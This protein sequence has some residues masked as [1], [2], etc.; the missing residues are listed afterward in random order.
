META[1]CLMAVH[2]DVDMML[3]FVRSE[4]WA[5]LGLIV[6]LEPR[7]RQDPALRTLLQQELVAWVRDAARMYA[8]PTDA[9]RALFQADA[10][11]AALVALLPRGE[12]KLPI[13]LKFELNNA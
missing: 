11:V 3:G 9:Q 1:L 13:R 6:Q 7:S 12:E 4:P 8:K 5:W 2:D 10:S